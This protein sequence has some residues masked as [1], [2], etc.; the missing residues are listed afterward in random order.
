[1]TLP[2]T[3]SKPSSQSVRT[4]PSGSLGVVGSPGRC[5]VC[6]I[7]PL[8]GRQT[9]CSAACRRERSRARQ[10]TVLREALLTV[11]AQIDALLA[12]AGTL[13]GERRGRRKCPLDS[14]GYLTIR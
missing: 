14:Q 3:P 5:P 9:V 1:M 11:R 4:L 2:G 7:A 8:A 13:P 10:A 6:G 12:L